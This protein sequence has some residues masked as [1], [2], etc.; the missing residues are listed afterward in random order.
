M[1]KPDKRDQILDAA[2]ILFGRHGYDSAPV[3]DICSEAGVNVAMV[4]YYFGSKEGLFREMVRRKTLVM[5]GKLEVLL[6][7]EKMPSLDKMK[8]V[9]THMTERV[10]GHKEFTLSV[11]RELS[12]SDEQSVRQLIME[13]F[14][15]NMKLIRDIIRNGIKK[16]E[17]RKVDIE[18][19]LATISGTIWNVISTAD[20][21][22]PGL[23]EKGGFVMDSDMCKKRLLKHLHTLIENHLVIK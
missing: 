15:P 19:T 9:V 4:N 6:M 13:L 23:E 1:S 5:R 22:I 18:F 17:F 12:K 11:I 10:F 16:K 14:L 20:L 2:E 7:D 21:M 8:A 3:R